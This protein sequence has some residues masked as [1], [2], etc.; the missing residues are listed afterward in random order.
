MRSALARL[1]SPRS[2]SFRSH[3]CCRNPLLGRIE[4]RDLGERKIVNKS[5]PSTQI[6]LGGPCREGLAVKCLTLP[7]ESDSFL[8]RHPSLDHEVGG[9][10][11]GTARDASMAVDQHL[12]A[13]DPECVVYE[14]GRL[15]KVAR[16]VE[17]DGVIR[18]NAEESHA[19]VL[20]VGLLCI[21]RPPL[22]NGSLR[23]IQVLS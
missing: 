5:T 4:R 7:D 8:R 11:G 17:R 20:V 22:L 1:R 23:S 9:H 6:E 12:L 18:R 2:A 21:N 3:S 15:V 13:F 10:N 19:D 16:Q 14:V